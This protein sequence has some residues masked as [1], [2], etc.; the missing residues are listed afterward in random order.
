[1]KF[2]ALLFLFSAVAAHAAP[3]TS[4]SYTLTPE[5][6]DDAGLRA[7]SG[8]YTLN[9]SGMSGGAALSTNYTDRTGFAG[10]LYDVT[11]MQVTA[12]P[13]TINEN[14]TRQLNG[15]PVLD[16]AT[17][18]AA[19][20]SSIA[21]NVL[22]GPIASIST[23][24]LATAATVYQNTAATVQG[25]FG[26]VSGTLALTVLNVNNDDFGS[27]AADGLS[28]LW[29]VQNF[30]L[31]N[32][33]AGPAANPDADPYNNLLEYAFGTN[34]NNAASGPGSI[35]YSAGL[36]TLLAQPTVSITQ[37]ATGVDYRAVFGRRKDWLAAGLL[38]KVQFSADL[39][40]WQDN[41]S[42]LN[43]PTF[44]ATDNLEMDAV[45]VPYP[46]FLNT[47]EKAQFFRVQVSTP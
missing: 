17:T 22:S 6:A 24:G 13:T 9:P 23:G 30:G 36:I 21:W 7:T 42:N 11:A 3:R 39:S 37:T 45:T 41:D 33:N 25:T 34:P 5:A 4:T 15:T 20:P 47:G 35:T 38:Y 27:Y 10:A 14:A 12:S 19:T 40:T 2:R 43:P 18:L 31:N 46:F 26:G 32:P 1:M 29:Q 8:N 28:D 16:D 44:V